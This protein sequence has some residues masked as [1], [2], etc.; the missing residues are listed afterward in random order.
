METICFV[1]KCSTKTVD[2]RLYCAW[3]CYDHAIARGDWEHKQKVEGADYFTKPR[4]LYEADDDWRDLAF[5]RAVLPRG[6]RL[7]GSKEYSLRRMRDKRGAKR[8][9]GRPFEYPGDGLY[10]SEYRLAF[11][12]LRSVLNEVLHTLPFKDEIVIRMR[13]GIVGIVTLNTGDEFCVDAREH[14]LE[15]IGRVI[16]LSRERVRQLV[17]LA[18]W[19]L[20]NRK[21]SDLLKPFYGDRGR[22]RNIANTNVTNRKVTKVDESSLPFLPREVIDLW[23][24]TRSPKATSVWYLTWEGYGQPKGLKL[25]KRKIAW[26]Q[27]GIVCCVTGKEI[28]TYQRVSS[29][30]AAQHC[31]VV[32][33][34]E[35]V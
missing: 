25:G 3:H 9:Y 18:I 10:P 33:V 1:D 11:V 7:F 23:S 29:P 22:I 16:G 30:E 28:G 27:D 19:K 2:G 26:A 6:V 31:M 35:P 4:L 32:W 20:A 24:S 21:R 14:T 12:E 15:E 8:F 34:T 5:S 13:F 17:T